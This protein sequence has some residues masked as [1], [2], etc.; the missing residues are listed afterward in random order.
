LSLR[1]L[2]VHV[3]P[4]LSSRDL[5]ALVAACRLAAATEAKLSALV[6]AVPDP[7]DPAGGQDGLSHTDSACK[8]AH[9]RILAEAQAVGANVEVLGRS[10]HA[11]GIGE[12]LADHLKVSDLGLVAVDAQV[13]AGRRILTH[14]AIFDSGCP[15]LLVSAPVPWPVVPRRIVV[16]WDASAT[17]ARALKAAVPLARLAEYVEVVA[18]ASEAN[19]RLD[20]SGVAATRFL[21]MHG[22]SAEFRVVRGDRTDALP[23]LCAACDDVAAD[24]LVVGAMRHSPLRDM[25]LGGV[26][27]AL[28][29]KVPAY[30]V[31]ACG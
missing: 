16:G 18:V 30:P 27:Q 7:D 22:A 5:A 20:Q 13:S 14:A 3:D 2:T 9:A 17:A 28:L 26:T 19:V 6:F 29:R 10:S 1:H 25:I 8:A 12:V 15:C 4:A 11:Y 21:A 23:A 31:M 24:L